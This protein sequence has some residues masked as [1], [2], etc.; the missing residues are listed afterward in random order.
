MVG[1]AGLEGSDLA[2]PDAGVIPRVMSTLWALI[3]ERSAAGTLAFSVHVT[4][5]ELVRAPGAR[6]MLQGVG[7]R[8]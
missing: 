4:F 8:G 1:S 6:L 7:S 5:C 2:S 3:D